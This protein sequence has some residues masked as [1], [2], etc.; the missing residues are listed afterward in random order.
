MTHWDE[1]KIPFIENLADLGGMLALDALL[2]NEDRHRQ[3]ILLQSVG[4]KKN[5][6]EVW[7]IDLGN[8][9]VGFP[10]DFLDIGLEIPDPRNLARGIP[11]TNLQG[12]AKQSALR[13]QAIDATLI[14]EFCQEACSLVSEPTVD[15]Y[16]EVLK[17]R[18]A[19]ATSL[20][21]R[22]L[23]AIASR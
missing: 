3:N 22:Y 9:L 19:N 7:S 4:R 23:K 18:C 5:A 8:A 11:V 2:M 15:K 13:A 21:A 6:F 12:A 16:S 17:H 1:A 20:V 10:S 14:D